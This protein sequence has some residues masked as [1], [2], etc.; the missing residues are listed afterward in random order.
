[1]STALYRLL[2]DVTSGQAQS[3]PEVYKHSR[4]ETGDRPKRP[5]ADFTS[6][7]TFTWA[8]LFP[9]GNRQPFP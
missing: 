6:G 7:W 8:E 3:Q 2:S 1:V 4:R 9:P 5:S